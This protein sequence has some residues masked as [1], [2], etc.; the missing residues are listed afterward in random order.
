MPYTNLCIVIKFYTNSTLPVFSTY[1]LSI[2]LSSM[3][4]QMQYATV[5]REVKLSNVYLKYK[6]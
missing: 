1:K 3:L 2:I 6:R 4:K 5:Y